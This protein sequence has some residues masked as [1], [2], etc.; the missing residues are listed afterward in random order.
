LTDFGKRVV[1]RCFELGILPDL[2]HTNQFSAQDTIDLAI[3]AKKPLIASHSN[4]Y[5]LYP[6]PRNLRDEHFV[7]LRDNG[8]LVGLNFCHVHLCDETQERACVSHLV[9]HLEHYLSLGGENIVA[10]GGDWDG[11]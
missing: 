10:I 1:V 7:A 8:G 3:A 4:A 2:S 6:H 9:R 11:T 5:G